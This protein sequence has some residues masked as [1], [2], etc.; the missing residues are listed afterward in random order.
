VTAAESAAACV[1]AAFI[2]LHG[3]N[4]F[5]KLGFGLCPD[6]T[7]FGSLNLNQT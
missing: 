6:L 3:Q 5:R 4:A 2:G 1:V 7:I